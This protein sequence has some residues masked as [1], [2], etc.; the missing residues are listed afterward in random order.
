MII[1]IM[2]DLHMEIHPFK[3]PNVDADIV[4]LAGDIHR[5]ILG[6]EWAKETF[7]NT[8][9][10]MVAGNHEFYRGKWPD[11]NYAMVEAARGS[12]V[13]V[14]INESL[15]IGGVRFLGT[16]LW[17][18][19]EYFGAA[20][21]AISE[22]ACKNGISDFKQIKNS[23]TNKMITTLDMIEDH[24]VSRDWLSSRLKEPFDG[25]T[26]VV[27][28]HAP[29]SYSCHEIFRND[30]C[31]PAF[32]SNLDGLVTM[33][34]IWVHGHLHHSCDYTIENTRVVC[35]PRGYPHESRNGFRA[36]LVVEI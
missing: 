22:V 34:D 10:I 24:K 19:F 1:R 9:V 32:I 4:V 33:A 11:I 14:M 6:V 35:N 5:G 7:P 3:S 30:S 27:T 17:T 18:D 29:S 26:V 12:N 31:T 21:R 23:R 25:K 36:D 15:I 28:H 13:H 20:F 16:T 8:P 2:S